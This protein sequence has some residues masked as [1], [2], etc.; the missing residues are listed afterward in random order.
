MVYKVTAGADLRNVPG[1]FMNLDF[2]KDESWSRTGQR[3]ENAERQADLDFSDDYPDRTEKVG[4]RK[5]RDCH[6]TARQ[7]GLNRPILLDRQTEARTAKAAVFP[8]GDRLI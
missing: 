4:D 7:M 6:S 3:K 5:T 2:S 8:S 1:H